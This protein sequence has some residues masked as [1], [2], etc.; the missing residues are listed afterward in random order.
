MLFP[1]EFNVFVNEFY[2]LQVNSY[3]LYHKSKGIICSG[4][5]I[6]LYL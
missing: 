5:R 2:V 3:V 1:K 6:C 4:N